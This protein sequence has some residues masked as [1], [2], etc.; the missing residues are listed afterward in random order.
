MRKLLVSNGTHMNFCLSDGYSVV[1]DKRSSVSWKFFLPNA[2]KRSWIS[3]K[4]SYERLPVPVRAHDLCSGS[5]QLGF[6][7]SYTETVSLQPAL[8]PCLFIERSRKSLPSRHALKM[9]TTP[10]VGPCKAGTAYGREETDAAAG[11]QP[12]EAAVALAASGAVAEAARRIGA[13][14]QPFYRRRRDCGGPAIDRAGRPQR[15]ATDLTPDN[16]ILR[17]A[18]GGYSWALYIA[19]ALSTAPATP[20]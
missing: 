8:K 4:R 10:G 2:R 1:V 12:G 20:L 14:G 18:S 16:R 15:A 17:Q 11:D 3:R 6:S 9:P 5:A 19:A 7:C 13:T